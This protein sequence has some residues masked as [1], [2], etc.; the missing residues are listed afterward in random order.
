MAISS[1][2]ALS[3]RL[4]TTRELVFLAVSNARFV[5]RISPVTSNMSSRLPDSLSKTTEPFRLYHHSPST[6]ETHLFPIANSRHLPIGHYARYDVCFPVLMERANPLSV[7]PR[8]IYKPSCCSS[9]ICFRSWHCC[10][11]IFACV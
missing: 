7:H 8:L 6:S 4:S 1:L 10:C 3:H 11:R 9:L 2:L 5:Q